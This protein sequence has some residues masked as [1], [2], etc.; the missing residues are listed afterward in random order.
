[1]TSYQPDVDHR[2]G[3]KLK[4]IYSLVGLLV[5]LS[6]IIVGMVLGLSG[7]VGHTSWTASVI[8]LSTSL[9]DAAPGVVVFVVGIF[10]VWITRFSVKHSFE[11]PSPRREQPPSDDDD[12]PQSGGGS[13]GG[14]GGGT[15][16]GHV[17]YAPPRF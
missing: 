10:M 2:L 7:V 11:R 14:G 17:A 16:R 13:G 5:G 8:G 9:T 3:M 6:C 12:E 1:M 4:F 15:F